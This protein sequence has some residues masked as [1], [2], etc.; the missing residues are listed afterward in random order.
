MYAPG[1]PE[2]GKEFVYA[3]G[4]SGDHALT[5]VGYNDDVRFDWNDDVEYTNDEDINDD[6]KVNMWDWEIG[7]VKIANIG[8]A[9]GHP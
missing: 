6:G 4:T 1:T 2:A 7:A 5:I 8:V 3:W 9:G